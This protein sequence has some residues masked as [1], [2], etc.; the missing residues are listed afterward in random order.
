M[1]IS[2]SDFFLEAIVFQILKTYNKL[3]DASSILL[4]NQSP[5]MHYLFFRQREWVIPSLLMR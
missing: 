2:P 1:T 4:L 3:L 5:F